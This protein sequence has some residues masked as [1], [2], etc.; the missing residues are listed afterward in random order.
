M[1]KKLPFLLVLII[2]F[3]CGLDPEKRYQSVLELYRKRKATTSEVVE[4]A[5]KARE[6]TVLKE[7]N[8]K[9]GRNSLF[10]REGTDLTFWLKGKKMKHSLPENT[11]VADII[12]SG[13]QYYALAG[14]S[15][16]VYG[17]G[18]NL[19]SSIRLPGEN[20]IDAIDSWHDGFLL[21]GGKKL[22]VSGNDS[23]EA[24][25]LMGNEFSSP[26]KDYS[27]GYLF[28]SSD[29]IA[30]ARGYAG[31][32]HI[33]IVDGRKGK[34][35]VDK[36]RAASSCLYLDE[37]NLYYVS[38]GA[39]NW[40]II[41]FDIITGKKKSLLTFENIIN[42]ALF[43]TGLVLEDDRGVSLYDYSGS[44]LLFPVE[45]NLE[46]GVKDYMVLTTPRGDTLQLPFKKAF[47]EFS[48]LKKSL[49]DLF[50]VSSTEGI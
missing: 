28:R 23:G 6:G 14:E 20:K 39:G 16:L 45:G 21:L 26:N 4:A 3:S 25:Q 43:K 34:V 40:Q 11:E 10:M 24:K 15:V 27:R 5:V 35:L 8:I 38:G 41:C 49:P 48:S 9:T 12:K 13:L 32:Y 42:I 37:G 33:A 1:E 30:V 17:E 22:Y 19:E 29:L 18:S 7:V 50:M 36:I 2:L 47:E 46:A 44:S 31:H